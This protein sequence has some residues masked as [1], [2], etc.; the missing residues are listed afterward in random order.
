ME[1][2]LRQGGSLGWHR[3]VTAAEEEG[4][5]RPLPEETS[6]PALLDF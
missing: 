6:T 5:A 1:D 2:V 3:G 4:Q